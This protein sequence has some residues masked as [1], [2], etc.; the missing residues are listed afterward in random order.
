MMAKYGIGQPVR[1]L[2]DR[3]FLTGAGQFVDDINLP[4]QCYGVV[5][6]SPHAHAKIA[7]IDASQALKSPGVV[8]VLTGADVLAD[9]LGGMP[10]LFMPGGDNQPQSFQT[11][12]PILAADRVRC[13]GDRVA[14][15]LAETLAQAADA[16][17]KV[18]VSYDPLPAI[19]DL[20]GA[21]KEDAEK[22]WDACPS[23][24]TSFRLQYGSPISTKE[25]FERAEHVV[26]VRLVNNRIAAN[27]LEP[28]ATI[29]SYDQSDGTYLLYTSSQNPHGVRTLVARHVLHV[30]ENKVRVIAPDVGGG[31]GLKSNAHV[32]DPLVLWASKR[33][34]RPV[35]WTATRTEALVGDYHARDQVVY[36]EMAV[37]ADGKILAIR[38]DALQSVGAYT[39]AVCA[40]P[41]IFSLEFIP[42]V[43]DVTTIDLKTRG[44]FT[45][46][47]PVTAYR[48][49]GRPE[50]IYLVERL[51][52]LAAEKCGLDPIEIRRRNLIPP[53]A[54]PYKTATG[55]IYDSGEFGRVLDRAV[56]LSDWDGFP[57]RAKK[58]K[59]HGK[60]RGRGICL[61][62]EPAGHDN[63][64]MELRFDPGGT[65]TVVAGTHSHG[66]GHATTYAQMISEWLGVDVASVKLVQGDT[67]K[68]SF[69]RGTFGARSSMNG[70]AALKL[71]A[72]TVVARAKLMAAELLEADAKDLE[73]AGGQFLVVGTDRAL[74]LTE[75]AKCFYLP[76]G[77]ADKFGVGL[78]GVGTFGT[79]PSNKPNGCHVCEVEIDPETGATTIERFTVVDDAGRVINP[80]LCEGQIHGGVAQGVGQALLEHVIYESSS[81]QNLSASFMDYAMPKAHHFPN[82][83]T[84]FEEV[85]S[86][87]NPLG[88]KGIGEAGAI[89]A[90]T[91]V[92]NAI[93]HALRPLGVTQIEL[94]ATPMQVWNAIQHAKGAARS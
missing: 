90:P 2:E 62:I 32:E 26:S 82:F 38:A 9:G 35:K 11:L 84:A 7:G 66:Q 76:G 44:V 43:Y 70:G 91:A 12:R 22:I 45:N 24:N 27:S 23:P 41:I 42:N 56:H 59:N 57:E 36:G 47:S 93:N 52:E 20:E 85:P 8:S 29:G 25:A 15:V 67:D 61:Y 69:G 40:A 65:I 63:E 1:R 33:C 30:S 21:I 81:G 53:S 55:V 83:V 13:V 72:D 79:N 19:T 6:Y 51:T 94:P 16:L 75:V 74:S 28:R 88:V 3:R 68:V 64:R 77:I 73:F 34:G 46:T 48:G 78:E 54:I 5:L 58:S 50:A 60:A 49:T 89:G 71:A 17:E 4:H 31:F 37:A 10:P 87:T 39:S 86:K 92:M 18:E 14:F 80:L